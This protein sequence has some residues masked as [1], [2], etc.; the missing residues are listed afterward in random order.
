[1]LAHA[2]QTAPHHDPAD[3]AQFYEIDDRHTSVSGRN[4]RV[5]LQARP[6]KRWAMLTEKFYNSRNE[7]DN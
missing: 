6:Q 4:V 2:G 5:Q 7:E 3:C 1:M